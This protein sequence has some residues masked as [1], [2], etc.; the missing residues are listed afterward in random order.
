[1]SVLAGATCKLFERSSDQL[2]SWSYR[3]DAATPWHRQDRNDARNVTPSNVRACIVAT[4]LAF[5]G[6][7]TGAAQVP[8][9][10]SADSEPQ[11]ASERSWVDRLP[12]PI[13]PKGLPAEPPGLCEDKPGGPAWLDRMHARLYRT[14]CLTAARFDGFFGN[15]R[16]D[17][18]YQAT[19]GSLAVGMLWDERDQLDQSVRFRLRV[20][21][22]QL[23]E[24]FNA[25]IG[26]TDFDEEVTGVRD[27]FDSL[28]RQFGRESD[29]AVLLGLGYSQPGR[30]GGYFD[31]GIGARLTFPM[32]P[33]V[34][35]RY[36][37]ALPFFERNVLRLSETLFWK[38]S[39][40]IGATT[41]WDLERL[42]AE[43]FLFRWTGSG[44]LTQKT[45]GLLW[46][47]SATLYHNLGGGS[48]LAY[49]AAISG[50]SRRDVA[51]T[52]YGLRLIYRQRIYQDW[53]FLELRSSITWPRETLLERRERNLG[54]GVGLELLFGER[55][56][57]AR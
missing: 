4:I 32:D 55:G 9:P 44:T 20:H 22:P 14:M 56:S 5:H 8:A 51:I 10:E 25:F 16:F 7:G 57:D 12:I 30:A 24:R 19:H 50:E 53:L 42:L 27:D 13:E 15:A 26:R 43:K 31:G 23:D 1:M 35:G 38:N 45:E 41:R 37:L 11:E 36:R 48:A 6:I 18:E 2:G 21:L 29:D 34:K 39:E 3:R 47:S 49:Q 17:D 33:Y 46:F 40:G 52:D 28:P 54:A